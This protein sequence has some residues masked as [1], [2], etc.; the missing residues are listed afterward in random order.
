MTL[1]AAPVRGLTRLRRESTPLALSTAAA[2]GLGLAMVL[3]GPAVTL[4]AGGLTPV[5]SIV[6]GLRSTGFRAVIFAGMAVGGVGVALGAAIYRAMPTKL[7]REESVAG[8]VL[9]A[10]AAAVGALLLLF[11]TRGDVEVFARN[12]L[13]F[14]AV[15]P[16]ISAFLNGAKNTVFLA[17]TG[18]AVGAVLGLALAIFAI[19]K[20]AVVRAPARVYIN[21]FRGTPLLWQ[22]SFGYFALLA[23]KVELSTYTVAILVFGLNTAAYAA[24]VFRAGIQSIERGQL[25]AARSLGMS[26]AQAMRYTVVPQAFRRVIPPLLNEFVILIKD[27]SLVIFLGLTDAQRELMSVGQQGYANSFNATFFVATA[28]GYLAVS[29]PLIRLVNVVERRLR[30]GL[31]GV[32]AA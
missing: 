22:L 12:F 14:D 2:G 11:V 16:Q 30:S 1:E 4:T 17:V 21:F 15:G 29:L 32:T 20:R 13:D 18:E 7:A 9:G 23:I 25:E 28:L 31:V 24:E 8:A 6:E 3:L 26:Y 27:T 5:A 10:Q 19:S